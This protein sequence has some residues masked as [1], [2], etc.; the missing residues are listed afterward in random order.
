MKRRWMVGSIGIAAPLLLIGVLWSGN[1]ASG[2]E[3]EPL[4]GPAKSVL[5]SYEGI[6]KALAG[7]STTGISEGAAAIAKAIR[8]DTDKSFPLTIAEEA[9]RLTEARD[10]HAA[11]RAFKPLSASLIAWLEEHK[12]ES[13]GYQEAYC[14][15]AEANWLQKEA[16]I[17]NPY[18]GKKMLNC[19]EF[20]RKF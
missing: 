10:L 5:E 7:D 15:M 16:E 17:N 13:S 19:G 9:D 3:N 11:R 14:P 12:V 18:L 2:V 6:Q 20:D 1:C 4:T 8:D